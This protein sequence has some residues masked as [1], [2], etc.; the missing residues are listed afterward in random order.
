MISSLDDG[1]LFCVE[2]PAQLMTFA[3]RDG[4][5]FTETAD[6]QTMLQPG[7]SAVVTRGQY[8]LVL[9]ED[10]PHVPPEA[11]RPFGH[12]VGDVHKI[13]VPGGAVRMKVFAYFLFQGQAILE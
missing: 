11:G 9:D 3:G 7:R 5:K 10:S 13:L 1:I 4:L 2:A 8:L 6:V 12:E